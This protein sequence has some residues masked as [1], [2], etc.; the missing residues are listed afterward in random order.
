VLPRL[1]PGDEIIISGLEHHAN[2]VP[3]QVAAHEAGARLRAAPIDSTGQ[4][5]FAEYL[6]LFTPRTRFVSVTQVS[7]SLGTITPIG[8]LVA[9]AHARGVPVCVDG[10]QSVA[11]IPVNVTAL[12]ADFFVFSGH[13]IFGPTGIG[14]LYGTD[15]ALNEA[16]PYQTGGNMIAD[17]TLEKTVYHGPPQKFEAGTGNIADA[18]GLGAAL[19]YVAELG[20]ENI[21]AYEESL[22]RYAT[23]LINQ[24][25]KV[26]I[27]G[28]AA[29]KAS[30][31]SFVVEGKTIE[32][33]GNRLS[34]AG[35][36]VRAGHHCSQPTIRH[37]GLEG[38]VRASLAFY[39]TAEEIDYFIEVLRDIA[40]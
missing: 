5:I 14:V 34:A 19:E 40:A 1:S 29:S 12:G 17:V 8:S 26:T 13:K 33:V 3:W 39:N 2:V 28:T 25:P 21:A 30:V 24:I 4:I 35:V 6:K 16:R 9:G 38:T 7:N 18:V 15:A 23:E 37:F 32:E 10:A 20:L 22:L 31:I 27:I 36:A 11:H